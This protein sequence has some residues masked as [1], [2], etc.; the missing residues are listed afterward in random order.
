MSFVSSADSA[1]IAAR[2]ARI[3]IDRCDILDRATPRAVVHSNVPCRVTPASTAGSSNPRDETAGER[4]IVLG[5]WLVLL[6]QGTDVTP[7]CQVR[8]KAD[9]ATP[10]L[11]NRRFA[12]AGDLPGSG[13]RIRKVIA[14]EVQ[15]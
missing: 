6:P 4:A 3:L 8:M 15:G 11:Q 9:T 5:E 2:L 1:R 12:V 7:E 14:T 10:A 13:E